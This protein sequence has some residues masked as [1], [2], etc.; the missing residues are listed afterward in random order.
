MKN[1]KEVKKKKLFGRFGLLL[2][3][4][5]FSP[6]FL[7][8][9]GTKVPVNAEFKYEFQKD[10]KSVVLS[11][12]SEEKVKNVKVIINFSPKDSENL[13]NISIERGY[14]FSPKENKIISFDEEDVPD[15]Y[16][17]NTASV[18]FQNPTITVYGF[19]DFVGFAAI[20][21]VIILF[22]LMCLIGMCS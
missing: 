21:V 2:V 9:C 4:I 10:F 13:D 16:K 19:W 18:E 11:N 15:F 17:I 14:S 5:L 22:I 8:G 12:I 20:V 6:L 7:T 3:V 1:F